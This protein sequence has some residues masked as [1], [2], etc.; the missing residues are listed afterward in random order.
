MICIGDFPISFSDTYGRCACNPPI[1]EIAATRNKTLD[2]FST[3]IFEQSEC[4]LMLSLMLSVVQ[5][6]L[7]L[8][9]RV[10]NTSKL[11]F[12]IYILG[13]AC[14]KLMHLIVGSFVFLRMLYMYWRAAFFTGYTVRL[15]IK[16]FVEI[17]SSAKVKFARS[18]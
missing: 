4:L 11:I 14:L 3:A 13:G 15:C 2:D 6:K 1:N 12:W 18:F 9:S 5:R 8:K 16:I 17:L 7:S 10:W